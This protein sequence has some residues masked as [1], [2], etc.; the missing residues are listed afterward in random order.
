MASITVCKRNERGEV[1][2]E[3]TGE[4]IARGATHVCVEAFFMFDDRDAGYVI[5]KRGDRFVEWHYSERWYN[6][7][8]LYD[9]DDGRF[10]GWYCN[11]TRPA[12]ITADRVC[13]DDLALDA[14]VDPSREVLILDEDEFAALDLSEDER[15]AARQAVE[16]IRQ[17]ARLHEPPFT[18]P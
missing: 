16:T 1:V 5:Y 18:A 11:I 7:F 10:K 14:F 13:A 15:R 2:L 17:A 9:R 4:V 3:Y 6:V 12:V 8:Q